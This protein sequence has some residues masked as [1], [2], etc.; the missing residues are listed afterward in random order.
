MSI[1]IWVK[2]CML[3]REIYNL[4]GSLE[5]VCFSV[6]VW[7]IKVES[8]VALTPFSNKILRIKICI[9]NDF[10]VRMTH[11]LLV[12]VLLVVLLVHVLLVPIIQMPNHS[13]FV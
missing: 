9:L 7:K 4:L 11:L 1:K 12:L 10:S 2:Y 8:K 6:F 13:H 3:A 5:T